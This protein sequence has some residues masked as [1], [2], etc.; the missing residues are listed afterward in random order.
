MVDDRR[1]TNR[2]RFSR[3]TYGDRQ[4]GDWDWHRA[5][6]YT[7]FEPKGYRRP[8]HRLMNDICERLAQHGLINAQ[9]IWV[10]VNQGDV[11]LAG[12]VDN[13]Q[14]KHMAEDVAATVFGVREIHNRLRVGT[15]AGE[16]ER[17]PEGEDRWRDEVG[18]SGVYPVSEMDEAPSGAEVQGM[19]GWGQGERGAEG[20][21]D[22]GESELRLEPE[23]R[24]RQGNE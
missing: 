5:G 19:K 1:R 4:Q 13:R 17:E 8:D 12:R 7:G 6:P 18:Q 23:S 2:G 16:Q 3:G 11:S 14:Q 20:Y 21:E 24:G 22:S 10:G 15:G 9:D